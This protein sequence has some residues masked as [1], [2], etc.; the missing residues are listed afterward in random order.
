MMRELQLG[1]LGSNDQE[2]KSWFFL[3]LT[4]AASLFYLNGRRK[5]LLKRANSSINL[6]AASLLDPVGK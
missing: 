6:Q 5:A 1:S 4:N 3:K 2:L